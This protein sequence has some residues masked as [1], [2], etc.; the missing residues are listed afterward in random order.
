[1]TFLKS[2]LPVRPGEGRALLGSAW[3][4]FSLLAGYYVLRPLR[5][6]FGAEHRDVLEYLWSGTF[7]GM[8]IAA[9]LYGW[10]V[11]HFP[12][13]RFL[14]YVY[15]FFLACILGFYVFFRWGP[16]GV[17]HWGEWIY[18]VWV[19]VFN[20]FVVS[21]FWGFLADIFRNEQAKRLF[22]WIMSGGTLGGIVGS[23]LTSAL[24]DKI[25]AIHLL[26]L[27][28]LFL[29]NAAWALRGLDRA[30]RAEEEERQESPEAPLGGGVWQGLKLLGRSRYLMGI[31]LYLL[32]FTTASTFLYY[33][34][35]HI[36]GE[37]IQDRGERT[38]LYA[39]INLAVNSLTLLC[40]WTLTVGLIRRFGLSLL[41]ILLPL[42]NAAGF[43]ALGA[44]PTL[45]VFATFE[46]SRRLTNFAFT[47][48]ARE[49]LYTVVSRK[50]KYQ[51]KP[52][53]DTV[54]YRGGDFGSSWAFK[55]LQALGMSLGALAYLAVPLSLAWGVVGLS[56]A[57]SHR[58]L[59]A[60][61]S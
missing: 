1:M 36:V 61:E 40:Q 18:Y 47:K 54:V 6:E 41:L 5:E 12:R 56:L 4:H 11:S 55:G 59:A 26:L 3:L 22:P 24:A 10:L 42:V 31:A 32:L 25:A 57:R 8:L 50:E 15:R 38:V 7:F 58:R 37:A 20:L 27:A 35:S 9:P 13:R 23:W 33:E 16:E 17:S 34:Q 39:R 2:I 45:A 19:S 49:I 43:L 53:I 48:P 30:A 44:L 60:D 21:V 52:F 46:I 28:A 29:E 14:P 51:S